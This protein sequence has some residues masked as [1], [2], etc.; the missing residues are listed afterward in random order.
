[1]DK[2]IS[3]LLFTVVNDLERT[4]DVINGYSYVRTIRNILIGK[5]DAA[6]APNFSGKK[7]YGLISDLTLEETET[8][9]DNMVKSKMLSCIYTSHGK[10]YCTPDYHDDICR[11]KL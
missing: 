3:C 6:I 10:L 2:N 1:M 7:Y 5:S 4:R 11:R 8:M 9:M